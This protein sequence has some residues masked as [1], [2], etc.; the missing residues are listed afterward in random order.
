MV[1]DKELLP[2]SR[3][4]STRSSMIYPDALNYPD[5]FS[6]NLV[7]PVRVIK[8][9]RGHSALLRGFIYQLMK[10]TFEIEIVDIDY[11]EVFKKVV[12]HPELIEEQKLKQSGASTD[13]KQ[14]DMQ[15]KR[16][17]VDFIDMIS[18]QSI[19]NYEFTL[20]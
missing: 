10:L 20:M 14:S 12:F 5:F 4:K 7:N 1:T 13:R 17:L 11:A 16:I 3:F 8:V 18:Q 15:Y 6:T 19:P 9:V 2:L